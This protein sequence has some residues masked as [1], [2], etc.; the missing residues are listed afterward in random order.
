MITISPCLQNIGQDEGVAIG[1][2]FNPHSPLSEEKYLE[3][4]TLIGDAPVVTGDVDAYIQKLVDART[5]LKEAYGY[6][7]AIVEVW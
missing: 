5:I 6:S 1:L 7:D 4:Q 3:L 2:R